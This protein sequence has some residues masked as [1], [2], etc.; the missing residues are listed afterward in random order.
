QDAHLYLSRVLLS[1]GKFSALR[2]SN[3]QSMRR[4]LPTHD[5]NE[6]EL[7]VHLRGRLSTLQDSL[8]PA[9]D[10]SRMSIQEVPARGNEA[11]H[12]AEETGRV[13]RVSFEKQKEIARR[14]V[15]QQR[16]HFYIIKFS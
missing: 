5:L 11:G 2:R 15:L 9:D 1:I 13:C 16:Y 10:L 4:V 12:G 8:S 14:G 7:R 3:V 6:Y